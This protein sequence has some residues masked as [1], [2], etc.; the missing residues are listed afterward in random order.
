[1]ILT[2]IQVS[3]HEREGRTQEKKIRN[4]KKKTKGRGSAA[5]GVEER[6]VLPRRNGKQALEAS[7]YSES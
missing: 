1:M 3:L 5:G 6:G 7:P 2:V 4:E